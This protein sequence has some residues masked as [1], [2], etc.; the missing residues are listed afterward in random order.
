MQEDALSGH[1]R[2]HHISIDWSSGLVAKD[3][4]GG[5]TSLHPGVPLGTSNLL[6]L[7]F[8]HCI[9][10]P[11][12]KPQ[13]SSARAQG[14][15]KALHGRSSGCFCS[16]NHIR[17]LLA[18]KMYLH[19]TGWDNVSFKAELHTEVY[20]GI[21]V[22]AELKTLRLTWFHSKSLQTWLQNP[23]NVPSCGGHTELYPANPGKLVKDIGVLL[24]LQQFLPQKVSLA[25]CAWVSLPFL[26][27]RGGVSLTISAKCAP[28][29]LKVS[30]T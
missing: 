1:P 4:S 10:F 18:L 26:R 29:K 7:C 20:A 19:C 6:A 9:F 11:A 25:A 17:L 14:A 12:N 5:N 8:C 16:Y 3:C 15:R 24:H 30:M 23:S 21:S 28:C 13:A 2:Q 22:T 27:A